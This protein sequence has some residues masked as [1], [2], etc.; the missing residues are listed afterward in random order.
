M[1]AKKSYQLT[2][3]PVGS[4]RE[5]WQVS[6]PLILSFLSSS[7]MMLSDRLFLAHESIAALNASAGAGTAA[8]LFLVIPLLLSSIT[9]VFVGQ[10]HGA[11]QREKMGEPVWQMLW[12]C[13]ALSPLFIAIGLLVAPLLFYGRGSELEIGYFSHLLFFGS[14]ICAYPALGGFFIGK[15]SVKVVT[16]CTVIDCLLNILLDPL[17]IFGWKSIPAMGIS[18]AAIAT[19]ISNVVG[20]TALFLIFLQKKYRTDYGSSSWRFN[21]PLFKRCVKV[22]L[23]AGVGQMSECLAH[24]AFFRLA[25][26]AGDHAMT[27][28]SFGQ[29][30]YMAMMFSIQGVSKGV[31]AICS[32]LIGA[33]QYHL[34]SSMLRS[35]ICLILFFTLCA[36]LFLTTAPEL[37]FTVCVAAQDRD[38]LQDPFFLATLTRSCL[39]ISIFYLFD[40]LCQI[41]ASVLTAAEDTKFLMIIGIVFTWLAYFTPVYIVLHLLQSSIDVAWGCLALCSIVMSIAYYARYKTLR[42]STLSPSTS[43]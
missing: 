31:M 42:R 19:G 26:F 2:D 28:A 12:L 40:A 39:F 29:T 16:I 4:I 9:E 18:G 33:A 13:L 15:G 22:G 35:A 38:L 20:S 41:F 25:L 43:S 7:I 27:I 34:I 5:I 17:L 23:P 11:N 36:A 6:Y 37:L 8:W 30:L 3:H 32:N 1:M 14:F 21:Y 10:Y 24:F